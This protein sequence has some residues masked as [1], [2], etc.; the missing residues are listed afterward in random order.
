MFKLTRWRRKA[1]T[2]FGKLNTDPAGLG[3]FPIPSALPLSR[4]VV[5]RYDHSWNFLPL[6]RLLIPNYKRI[7][8]YS[9]MPRDIVDKADTRV[10][11]H[12][13]CSSVSRQF[14]GPVS[15]FLIL[16]RWSSWLVLS[17][18]LRTLCVNR[19]LLLHRNKICE[20]QIGPNSWPPD[21]NSLQFPPMFHNKEIADS[22]LIIMDGCI[23]CLVTCQNAEEELWFERLMKE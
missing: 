13:L 20:L 7:S 14:H 23:V 8:N 9:S 1:T 2:S 10:L 17:I 5:M 16:K 3:W 15:G 12:Q 4:W 11:I 6:M 22:W 21:F 18:F 19:K